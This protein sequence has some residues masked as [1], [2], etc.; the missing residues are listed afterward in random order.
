MFIKSSEPLYRCKA[1]VQLEEQKA[2]IANLALHADVIWLVT[3]RGVRDVTSQITS[4]SN[5]SILSSIHV[6]EV[7]L[8]L[9][10]LAAD[11][12]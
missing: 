8:A 9:Y 3:P 1:A 10:P 12:I 2:A 4:A 7:S 6:Y 11:L 5:L